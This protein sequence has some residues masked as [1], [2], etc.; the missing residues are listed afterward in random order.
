MTITIPLWLI[1][2]FGI[3]GVMIAIPLIIFLGFCAYVGY[4]IITGNG[5][6]NFF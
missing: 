2:T 5:H 4:V 6:P 1:W 3:V